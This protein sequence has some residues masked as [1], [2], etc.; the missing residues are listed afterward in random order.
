MMKHHSQFYRSTPASWSR[1]EKSSPMLSNSKLGML[2]LLLRRYFTKFPPVTLMGTSQSIKHQV[3]N[4]KEMG[5]IFGKF[6]VPVM[7]TIHLHKNSSK[8]G[9]AVQV[10]NRRSCVTTKGFQTKTLPTHILGSILHSTLARVYLE[11]HVSS[12]AFWPCVY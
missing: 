7:Y 12:W 6:H 9:P 2:I 11:L 4:Q 10:A 1:I 5:I 3:I 8:Y